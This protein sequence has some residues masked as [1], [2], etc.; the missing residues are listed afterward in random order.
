MNI[1]F[2]PFCWFFDHDWSS[3]YV[4]GG[5]HFAG[6]WYSTCWRCG[7]TRP[8]RPEQVTIAVDLSFKDWLKN[9]HTLRGSSEGV[10]LSL[11]VFHT[12]TTFPATITLESDDDANE[13][14]AAIKAGYQPLFWM[15][16]DNL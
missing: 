8:F 16:S 2:R 1:I 15:W 14:I 10:E 5:E 7:E 3:P 11:G 12:G 4:P 6:V 13:L 9:G